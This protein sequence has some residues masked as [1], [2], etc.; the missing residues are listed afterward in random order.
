MFGDLL[1]GSD[2]GGGAGD[3]A[4]VKCGQLVGRDCAF[5]DFD[6]AGFGKADRGLAGDAVQEAVGAGGVA[7]S[8][9][10]CLIDS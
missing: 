4:F 2:L 7:P 1:D 10:C 8:K 5:D 3:E 6:L 9:S